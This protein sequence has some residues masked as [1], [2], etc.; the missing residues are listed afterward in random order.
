[1]HN[2]L[3][4]RVS[5]HL[6]PP[7]LR[8]LVRRC[9][10][11]LIRGPLPDW[12]YGR[13][14]RVSYLW[15]RSHPVNDLPCSVYYNPAKTIGAM[16]EAD[17]YCIVGAVFSSIVCLISMGLFWFFEQKPGLAVVAN[18]S[19]FLCIGIAMSLVAWSKIWMERPSFNTGTASTFT[20]SRIPLLTGGLR[21]L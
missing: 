19:L 13:N 2:C 15:H 1:M 5:L 10:A 9:P 12:A 3:L 11:Q 4:Y 21:S 18:V 17:L 8:L 20:P 14:G 7:A 6:C 16:F